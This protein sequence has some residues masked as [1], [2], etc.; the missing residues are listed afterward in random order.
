M[1]SKA[2]RLTLAQDSLRVT[3]KERK[4]NIARVVELGDNSMKGIYRKIGRAH[5]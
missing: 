4:V 3:N 2:D 1:N 5:V